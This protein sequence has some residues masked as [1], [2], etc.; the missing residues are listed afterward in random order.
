MESTPLAK[1]IL[2]ELAYFDIFEHPL[3][4]IELQRYAQSPGT[5][6]RDILV[7]LDQGTWLKDR[8]EERWGFYFL[9][10]RNQIVLTRLVRYRDAEKKFQKALAFAR[11]FA[12]FPFV[13]MVAVCNSQAYSN[14]RPE[15]DIDFFIVTAPGRIWTCRWYI[16]SYLKLLGER[17][18]ATK[19]Q[20]KICASFFV[21]A[22]HLNLEGLRLEKSDIY[23]HH[24]V[25]QLAP[26][27]DAGTIY[28]QFIAANTWVADFFPNIV[29]MTLSA[30][31]QIKPSWSRR[32]AQRK[33]EFWHL[34]A[35]GD[36]LERFYEK[37]QRRILPKAL[38]DLANQDS[39]V[40]LSDTMLKF[41]D[42]DRRQ[43][44][45][46]RWRK[47]CQELGI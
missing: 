37:I 40:I 29:P 25:T 19:T 14:S 1:S 18:T 43:Q 13:R 36:L 27:Y 41:H 35:W 30:S 16:T 21:T 34:G 44:Y 11:R 15:S 7:A 4:A 47:K 20:D 45:Q 33:A 31:R 3:T 24:W 38:R 42:N 22:D 17:P 9:K 46:E 2:S 39:R 12:L 10:G 26:L 8:T 6:L 32:L 23:L 28:Q 5:K